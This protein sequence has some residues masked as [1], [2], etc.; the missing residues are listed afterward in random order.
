M[1]V[2]LSSP[3]QASVQSME[4]D[5]RYDGSMIEHLFSTGEHLSD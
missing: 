2:A 5:G 3:V 1:K 4:V